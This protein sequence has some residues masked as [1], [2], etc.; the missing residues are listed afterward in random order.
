MSGPKPIRWDPS[1]DPRE[2]AVTAFNELSE[3]SDILLVLGMALANE[4]CTSPFMELAT[5]AS[6]ARDRVRTGYEAAGR[7][8][9]FY[10][11]E[12]RKA[13]GPLPGKGGA[14]G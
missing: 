6:A 12:A 1:A 9:R 3:V 5:V 7:L 2:D 4:N 13:L 8:C 14:R 10:E 11:L